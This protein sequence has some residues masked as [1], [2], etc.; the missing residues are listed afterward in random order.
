MG[1][2]RLS[3]I[4]G[5][6]LLFAGIPG[7]THSAP[8]SVPFIRADASLTR[9]NEPATGLFLVARRT[10]TDPHFR[11]SVIYLLQHGAPGTL[12]LV[13]NRP[14]GL[15][16]SDAVSG[17]QDM[18]TPPRRVFFG[19][20]VELTTVWMLIRDEEESR[21]VQHIA[22]DIYLSGD[23]T[24]LDR[25]LAERKPDDAL[26]FYM[27]H[28]GWLPGQLQLE[29]AQED[30]YVIHA[31]PALIFSADPQ[32]IWNRLIEKLDPSGIYAGTKP[33]RENLT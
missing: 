12:G 10:L 23:R 7:G 33:R 3:L 30:W 5:I 9:A 29:I 31:D 13:V 19:G 18:D 1:K 11:H 28:A 8:A 17:I 14:S 26:H 15:T 24:V 21:L 20:P 2:I 25:L 4:I 16:L 32:S 6:T 22:D 27:G